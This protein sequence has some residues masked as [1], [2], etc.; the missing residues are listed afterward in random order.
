MYLN[1]IYSQNGEEFFLKEKFADKAKGFYVD[2]GSYHPFRFSNTYWAYTRGWN[3]IN[4]EPNIDNF[5]LFQIFRPRDIN[6]QCGISNVEGVMKYY[7]FEEPALNTFDADCAQI[8]EQ[9]EK[10]EIKEIL[11][12]KV[13]RLDNILRENIITKIDFLDIDVEGAEMDVL[14]SIDFNF[15]IDCILLEQ[16]GMIS[17]QDVLNS[18]QN[19]FLNERGYVVTNKYGNTVIYEKRKGV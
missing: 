7:R 1:E 15:D 18:E 2:I 19:Q 3:G 13:R 5:E 14:K 4:I 6:I 16:L 11:D 8:Y 17:L 12:V 10:Q 9:V